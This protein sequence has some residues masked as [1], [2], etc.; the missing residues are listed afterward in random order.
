MWAWVRALLT[1]VK[2]FLGYDVFVS[3][4][5][6]DA[7]QY[8]DELVR[9]LDSIV[10]PRADLH[11]T[12]P[13]PTLPF[14]LVMAVAFSRVLVIACTQGSLQSVHVDAELKWF[15]RLSGGPVLP[16]TF[17]DVSVSEAI[18]WPRIAGLPVIGS[19]QDAFRVAQCVRFWKRSRRL[20]VGLCLLGLALGVVIYLGA[21]ANARYVAFADVERASRMAFTETEGNFI[22]PGVRRALFAVRSWKRSPNTAAL[23]IISEMLPSVSAPV[24]VWQANVSHITQVIIDETGQYIAVTDGKIATMFSRRG[25]RI[26]SFTVPTPTN[27]LQI[28]FGKR[29]GEVLASAEGQLC[30]EV[31]TQWSTPT[32]QS[33]GAK[34]KSLLSGT[35]LWVAISDAGR[36]TVL[37]TDTKGEVCTVAGEA[38]RFFGSRLLVRTPAAVFVEYMLVGDSC[39]FLRTE[40]NTLTTVGAPSMEVAWANARY[41]FSADGSHMVVPELTGTQLWARDGGGAWKLAMH[42][43]GGYAGGISERNEAVTVDEDSFITVAEL[44]DARLV[45]SWAASA[46]DTRQ[47]KMFDGRWRNVEER[48]SMVETLL[49]APKP[50]LSD[51]KRW[52][53]NLWESRIEISDAGTGNLILHL[54][55]SGSGPVRMA[56]S[57]DSRSIAIDQAA[58]V[59]VWSLD[60]EAYVRQLCERIGLYGLTSSPNPWSPESFSQICGIDINKLQKRLS[61]GD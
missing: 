29:A 25:Q 14:G 35:G 49:G 28:A 34:G 46:P 40:A 33:L 54:A 47:L 51:D 6:A 39:Q 44:S 43:P 50:Y 8:I 45:A 32:C 24:V 38:Q 42:L 12:A 52:E 11:E 26:G 16:V 59:Q 60:S 10:A 53:F 31:A 23:Q 61:G 4:S 22:G 7:S 15:R 9:R 21:Q 27:S 1:P 41:A 55:R 17:K 20:T 37:H 19:D 58:N 30:R 18:W 56:F 2:L 3:Y 36:V 57:G 13:G 48:D 5:R